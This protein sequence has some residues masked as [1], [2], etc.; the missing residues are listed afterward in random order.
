MRRLILVF[1]L[2]LLGCRKENVYTITYWDYGVGKPKAVRAYGIR[3][4]SPHCVEFDRGRAS[5]I[6]V[7]NVRFVETLSQEQ[8]QLNAIINPEANP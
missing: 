2:L 3:W 5:D 8:Q 4:S 1:C 7:C 6:V